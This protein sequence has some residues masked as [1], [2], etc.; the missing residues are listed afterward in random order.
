MQSLR[1]FPRYNTTQVA[2]I[3]ARDI[4]AEPL[5]ILGI[6]EGDSSCDEGTQSPADHADPQFA[7]A[8]EQAYLAERSVQAV[9]GPSVHRLRPMQRYQ[10]GNFTSA[11]AHGGAPLA[12]AST[13]AAV[14]PGA[15]SNGVRGMGAAHDSSRKRKAGASVSKAPGGMQLAR[16]ALKK[17]AATSNAFIRACMEEETL[18]GAVGPGEDYADLEDFI[19]CQPERDYNQLLQRRFQ[20]RNSSD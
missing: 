12:V 17:L 2:A 7:A 10:T 3:P 19:V 1:S 13:S 4:P 18:Q 11:A 16:K 14:C 6:R 15:G 20:Y 9:A 5:E 8:Y